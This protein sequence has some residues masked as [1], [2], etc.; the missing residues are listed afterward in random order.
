[1]AWMEASTLGHFMR[2]SGP[3]TY[4]IVNLTHVL[5]LATLFGSVLILDLRLLGAWPDTP[6]TTLADVVAPIAACGFAIAA[7]SGIGLIATKA[8]EYIG[9]PFLYIKF[10]AIAIGLLNA[11]LLHVSPAWQARHTRPLTA[12]ERR[13]LAWMGG[14]SLAC[15]L[16]A[17]GAGRLIG[18]W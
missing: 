3:W 7:T 18:Y 13:R 16:T 6:L 12:P 10:P 8:T 15:W 11:L 4:A 1:M 2:E 5:G 9:N 14:M 17:I